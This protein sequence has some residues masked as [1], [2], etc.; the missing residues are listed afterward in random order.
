MSE[1]YSFCSL[2]T[3]M[4]SENEPQI[5]TLLFAYTSFY[6]TQ[7]ESSVFVFTNYTILGRRFY[8]QAFLTTLLLAQTISNIVT[9]NENLL[10]HLWG[11][12]MN[13]PEEQSIM[14]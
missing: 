1:S 12:Y 10:P 5:R 13:V 9:S 7:D 14:L 2:L 3:F 11:A 4:D 8:F 6:A